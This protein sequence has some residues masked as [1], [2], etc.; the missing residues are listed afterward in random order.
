MLKGRV[1][2]VYLRGNAY[3]FAKQVNARRSFVSLETDDY[4]AAVQRARE[5]RDAPELQPAQ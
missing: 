2:G 1:K 3:R 5:I 4:V